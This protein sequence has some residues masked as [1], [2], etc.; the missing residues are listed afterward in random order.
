MPS[1]NLH[2]LPSLPGLDLVSSSQPS[3]FADQSYP[4]HHQYG[5]PTYTGRGPA[6][7]ATGGGILSRGRTPSSFSSSQGTGLLHQTG[8]H[9]AVTP[10]TVDSYQPTARGPSSALPRGGYHGHPGGQGAGGATQGPTDSMYHH[11]P[12]GPSTPAATGLAGPPPDTAIRSRASWTVEAEVCLLESLKSSIDDGLRAAGSFKPQALERVRT[13]L[14]SQLF[15]AVSQDQVRTKIDGF[16]RLSGIIK[17]FEVCSG[18]GWDEEL[19]QY[20]AEEG[21]W[22]EFIKVSS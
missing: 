19:E 15:V 8:G 7:G 11:P 14:W 18:L 4:P 17:K 1:N 22:R 6:G 2:R 12:P 9:P 21:V 5:S 16:K 10:I 13:D 3:P 20:T